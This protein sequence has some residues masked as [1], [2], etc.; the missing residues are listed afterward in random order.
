MLLGFFFTAAIRSNLNIING[1]R[2]LHVSRSKSPA[3][4]YNKASQLSPNA[5]STVHPLLFSSPSSSAS[6][7][8]DL[9]QSAMLPPNETED[10]MSFFTSFDDSLQV[11]AGPPPESFDSEFGKLEFDWSSQHQ[12]LENILSGQQVTPLP[13]TTTTTPSTTVYSDYSHEIASSSQYSVDSSLLSDYSG[14]YVTHYSLGSDIFSDT[15]SSASQQCHDGSSSD[16]Y[17]HPVLELSP[18]DLSHVMQNLAIPIPSAAI[19]VQVTP[20]DIACAKAKPF[21]C[22]HCPF[23]KA[24]SMRPL[25]SAHRPKPLRA[26]ITSKPTSALTIRRNQSGSYAAS[27]CAASLASTTCAAITPLIMGARGRRFQPTRTRPQV[28]SWPLVIVKKL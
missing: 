6:S 12:Y 3:H 13:V 19:P 27:A 8:I 20:D 21:K 28:Q 17:D 11:S 24:D 5:A 4:P 16:P 15:L 1:N 25:L 9:L 2:R 7:L 26:S 14:A 18:A 23:G 10:L 22:P